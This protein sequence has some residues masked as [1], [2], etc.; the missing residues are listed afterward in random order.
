MNGPQNQKRRPPAQQVPSSLLS[1][2][3]NNSLFGLLGKKCVV[4]NAICSLLLTWNM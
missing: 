3:E 4:C 1:D 2:Q